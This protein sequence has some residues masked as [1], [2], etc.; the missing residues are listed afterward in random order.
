MLTRERLDGGPLSLQAK[1]ALALSDSA[2]PEVS[3]KG[4]RFLGRSL[5]TEM[6]VSKRSNRPMRSIF[7][8]CTLCDDCKTGAATSGAINCTNGGDD[9]IHLS[10]AEPAVTAGR[11]THH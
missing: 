5:H 1:A 11:A 6:D 4:S 2:D 10:S 3:D 9:N 7:H 8:K